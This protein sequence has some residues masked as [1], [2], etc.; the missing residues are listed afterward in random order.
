MVNMNNKLNPLY[1]PR[2]KDVAKS[3]YVVCNINKNS[4]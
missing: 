4:R 1:L 3:V 2:A